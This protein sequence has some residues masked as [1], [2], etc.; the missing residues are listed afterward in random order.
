MHMWKELVLFFTLH[1][2]VVIKCTAE[3]NIK[4]SSQFPHIY[5]CV[6]HVIPK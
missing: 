3:F 6:F 2:L 5:V 1:S 4:Q